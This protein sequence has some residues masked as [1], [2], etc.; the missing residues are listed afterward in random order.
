[1]PVFAIN[2]KSVL[3]IHVPKTGGTTV[4]K[5][6]SQFGPMSLHDGG[7]GFRDQFRGGWLSKPVPL[8][9]LHGALLKRL[10][11]PG[12]FDL[13][14]MM[15]RDPVQRMISE[16]RHSRNLA[17]PEAMLPFSNWLR[18][19]LS[20]ARMDP[21]F[22]NNHFRSQADYR[23]D[24]AKILHFEDGMLS[25]LN[26]ISAAIGLPKLKD[27]PH[28]R[29]S[30]NYLAEPSTRDIGLIHEAFAAD[31]KMFPH[32][33]TVSEHRKPA[34]SPSWFVPRPMSR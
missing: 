21:A 22:R 15:V 23:I 33:R 3:F 10:L 25:C 1:M 8:Q 29:R 16:Y 34:V 6:L 28:E 4:E 13:V 2:G 26:E 9:H 31:Y 17:R 32:Y 27:L 30:K 20:L 19:S 7:K 11:L 5:V 14:F 18:M 12:Q 24:G